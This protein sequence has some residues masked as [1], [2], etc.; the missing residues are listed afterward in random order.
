MRI[1]ISSS[2]RSL[3]SFSISTALMMA[4][5]V[6]KPH[7]TAASSM[8]ACWMSDSSPFGPSRPSSVS[9]SLPSAQTAR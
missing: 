4:P 3:P 7:W 6:Q 5:G 8:K 1:L 2:D 9:I